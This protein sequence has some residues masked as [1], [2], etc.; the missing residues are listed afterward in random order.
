M[1]TTLLALLS[2]VPNVHAFSR[3]APDPTP[4]VVPTVQDPSAFPADWDSK[5]RGPEFTRAT[6]KALDELGAELLA[7]NPSDA[8][9][10]CPTYPSLTVEGRRRFWLMLISAMT[11]FESSFNPAATFA[12]PAPLDGV[13]SRGLLQLSVASA[14]QSA[15]GCNATKETLHDPEG[16]LRCGVRIMRNRIAKHGVIATGSGSSARGLAS[17]WSVLWTT[18]DSRGSIIAKTRALAACKK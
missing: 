14:N 16:N 13:I 2:L 18:R 4:S 11:R 8:G 15:Y 5:P 6:L 1:T 3:K 10:F 17:Y 9:N 7:A 12:E